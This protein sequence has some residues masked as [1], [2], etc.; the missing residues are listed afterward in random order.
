MLDVTLK[1]NMTVLATS[2]CT[3]CVS[4]PERASPPLPA[5]YPERFGLA[6]LVAL[7]ACPGGEHPQS[8]GAM[9]I[10][11]ISPPCPIGKSLGAAGVP[12][13]SDTINGQKTVEIQATTENSK[14]K[15]HW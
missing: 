10:A 6:G 8:F 9:Y 5:G 2:A 13:G 1:L 12:L 4:T 7:L 11:G 14:S 15:L 3:S